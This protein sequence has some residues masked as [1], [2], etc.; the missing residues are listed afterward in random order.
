MSDATGTR[1]TVIYDGHCGVCTRL[2]QRVARLDTHRVLEIVASQAP[3]VRDRFPWI[4]SADYDE[5]LQVVRVSDGRTWNG[6][7]AV[8]E[9]IRSLRTGWVVSWLF[10]IPFARGVA[11]RAYRWF[12]DHR[13]ELGCS[14]HCAV[15]AISPAT[16]TKNS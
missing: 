2:V 15:Q 7:A 3:G 6:A 5:S 4:P 11:E 8:E 10:R 9:I 1:L 13:G 16:G 14:D 12:A